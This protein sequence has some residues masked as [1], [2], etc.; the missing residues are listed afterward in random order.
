MGNISKSYG[1]DASKH[2]PKP[3]VILVDGERRQAKVPLGVVESWVDPQGNVMDGLQLRKMGDVPD[4]G[5]V[6][7]KRAEF[8]RKGWVE[9]HQCPLTNGAMR[10]DKVAADLEKRPDEL[11]AA[12]KRDP[13]T[14]VKTAGGVEWRCGCPHIEW[15]VDFRRKKEADRLALKRKAPVATVAEVQAQI[16]EE[17]RQTNA[18]LVE[19]VKAIN[20]PKKGAVE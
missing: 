11:S 3:R 6:D 19:A 1:H 14:R 18:A 15:L 10:S 8:R 7:R 20:K 12:C 5:I 13:Q 17:T 9:H 2:K 16:L 4:Q